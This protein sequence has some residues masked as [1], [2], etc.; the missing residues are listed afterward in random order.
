MYNVKEYLVFLQKK[1]FNFNI[2]I[3]KTHDCKFHIIIWIDIHGR[4]GFQLEFGTCFVLSKW[5]F[6]MLYEDF[7][8]YH[9]FWYWKVKCKFKIYNNFTSK[10]P[11]YWYLRKFAL[12]IYEF[13]QPKFRNKWIFKEVFF[14]LALFR[15]IVY[16]GK[17]S[18]LISGKGWTRF[19]N[20]KNNPT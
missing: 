8:L 18:T 2:M 11:R 3:K 14:R 16:N 7:F 15:S 4:F 5:N 6:C 9:Q 12:K 20:Y 13:L 17:M 10:N 19:F 1:L